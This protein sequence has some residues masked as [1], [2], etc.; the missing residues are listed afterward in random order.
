MEHIPVVQIDLSVPLKVPGKYQHGPWH[1]G[2][3]CWQGG[4]S[5]VQFPGGIRPG[6]A[7]CHARFRLD[8]C[9]HL[10]CGRSRLRG[11]TGVRGPG[12]RVPLIPSLGPNP[13]PAP[14]ALACPLAFRKPGSPP[15]HT[16]HGGLSPLSPWGPPCP[17]AALGAGG[18]PADGRAAAERRVLCAPAG[19]PAS[20]Q[21]VKLEEERRQRQRLEKDRKKKKKKDKERKGRA[22]RRG[23]LLSESDE[24]VAPAQQVDIVTEEMPEVSPV[25]RPHPRACGRKQ[26]PSSRAFSARRARRGLLSCEWEPTSQPR[27]LPQMRSPLRRGPGYD[28]IF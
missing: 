15:S 8:L 11:L 28:F 19:M 13:P 27:V 18:D 7:S 14:T 17:H 26:A 22:R 25:G 5:R 24:D 6:H 3:P 4:G 12:P 10:G 2:S 20:D 9:C 23:S 21:Y 16:D 1:P